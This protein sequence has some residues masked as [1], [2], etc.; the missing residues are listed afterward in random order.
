MNNNRYYLIIVFFFVAALLAFYL[1][2]QTEKRIKK[3]ENS[4]WPQTPEKIEESKHNST[5][6]NVTGSIKDLME[7]DL[8]LRCTYSQELDKEATLEGTIYTD[9]INSRSNARLKTSISERQTNTIY[10]TDYVYIWFTGEPKGIKMDLQK[11]T[12]AIPANVETTSSEIPT[13]L[14]KF[15]QKL[16]FVCS[17]WTVT[18]NMFSP[19]NTFQFVDVTDAIFKVKDDPCLICDTMDETRKAQ[20]KKS[21]KCK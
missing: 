19:P 2:V 8:P 12:K 6:T 17:K 20:C 5:T 14:I 16:E 1:N 13:D 21:Y 9:G 15:D 18:E 10:T 11:Y 7:L 3:M 4:L